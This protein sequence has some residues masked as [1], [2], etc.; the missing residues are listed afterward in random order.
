MGTGHWINKV[1]GMICVEV[2][3]TVPT[4]TNVRFPF[5]R[6]Y[7]CTSLPGRM[8]SWIIGMRIAASR[9]LPG[10]VTRKQASVCRWIPPR[11]HVPV[12]STIR[13]RLYLRFPNLA[14]STSTIVSG[15][16]ILSRVVMSSAI[17]SWMLNNGVDLSYS[18]FRYVYLLCC[19]G[20]RV[21]FRKLTQDVDKLAIGYLLV[22]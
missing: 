5:V 19:V 21:A 16:P 3:I 7:C 17:F 22:L 4:E 13:P 11:T 20:D 6:D 18:C 9:L 2:Y 14:S 10:Q 1:L 15:P 12:P 8:N